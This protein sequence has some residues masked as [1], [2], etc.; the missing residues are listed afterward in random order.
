LE[1][2]AQL[3]NENSESSRIA[4]IG[5]LQ[6]QPDPEFF[7]F[8]LDAIGQSRS[9]F[10]QYQAL[11]SAQSFLPQLSDEQKSRLKKMII[12]QLGDQPAQ[13]IEAGS[14]RRVL[15]EM[16]LRKIE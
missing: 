13:S 2:I 6:T 4:A 3:I 12:T 8:I 1:K 11:S 15:S 16:I 5:I 7:H 10:E 9:E 14:D